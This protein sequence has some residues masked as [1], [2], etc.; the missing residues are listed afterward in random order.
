M[1]NGIFSKPEYDKKRHIR[2][3]RLKKENLGQLP[4]L[5]LM[6]GFLS[7][8]FYLFMLQIIIWKDALG[9][10]KCKLEMS[11]SR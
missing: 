2:K 5:H 4:G 11:L 3:F 9:E 6:L 1:L 10:L 7:K 8:H